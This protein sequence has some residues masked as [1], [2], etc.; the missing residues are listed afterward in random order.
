MTKMGKT[1]EKRI[2]YL[3]DISSNLLCTSVV[4]ATGDYVSSSTDDG[5]KKVGEGEGKTRADTPAVAAA[6]DF[7]EH[8]AANI[9]SGTD[10]SCRHC[11]VALG[12]GGFPLGVMVWPGA[13]PPAATAARGDAKTWRRAPGAFGLVAA[14]GTAGDGAA[15]AA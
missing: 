6:F 12:G 7:F 2:L 11:L 5:G 15:V 13:S 4:M 14:A 3:C 1:G 9:G 10:S 8:E